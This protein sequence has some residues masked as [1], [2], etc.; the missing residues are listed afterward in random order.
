[1]KYILIIFLSLTML[2]CSDYPLHTTGNNQITIGRISLG[3]SALKHNTTTGDDQIGY[4]PS[5]LAYGPNVQLHKVYGDDSITHIKIGLNHLCIDS[6]KSKI[7]IG[8]YP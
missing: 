8:Y 7:M 4:G 6:S 5:A 2:I 1:M 3:D